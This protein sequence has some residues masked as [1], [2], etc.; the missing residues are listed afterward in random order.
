MTG[1]TSFKWRH[2]QAD[3]ILQC[4]HWHLSYPLIYRHLEEMMSERGLS[5]D[6]T[7]IYHWVQQYARELD[8]RCRPS[9][10]PTN[11]SWRVDEAYIKVKGQ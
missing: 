1:S 4:M 9:L 6:H 2:F 3:I 10:R 7:T 11:G 8:K 5:D